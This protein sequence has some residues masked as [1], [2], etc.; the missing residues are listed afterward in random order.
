MSTGSAKSFS[1]VSSS[2]RGSSSTSNPLAPCG[3]CLSTPRHLAVRLAGV[4]NSSDGAGDCVG[5]DALNSTYILTARD[6]GS[7]CY[8]F[9]DNEFLNIVCG[10]W[11][12]R[13]HRMQVQA[14]FA[15]VDG[16]A[17]LTITA[18]IGDVG[19]VM[20]SMFVPGGHCAGING[21]AAM[22]LNLV[23]LGCDASGITC[24]VRSH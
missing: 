2:S 21:N 16:G 18:D 17:Q 3:G 7:C 15:A 10:G 8:L 24:H 22:V 23:T 5:C 6:D 4:S 1:S 14:C 9:S 11:E 20:F 12:I 19:L 13:D